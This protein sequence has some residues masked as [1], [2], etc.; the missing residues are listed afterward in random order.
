MPE[1]LEILRHSLAHVLAYA[2]KKFDPEVQFGIGPAI[3]DGFYYDFIFSKSVSDETLAVLEKEMQAIIKEDLPFVREE[4]SREAA[5][6][7]FANEPHKLELIRELP[8]G[9]VISIYTLGDFVD[10]CRGPHV[11]STKNLR[12]AGFTLSSL[13]GAYWRGNSDNDVM[14]RI[15]AFAF[16][17]KKELKVFLKRRE[18]ALKRDHRRLGE[19]LDLFV[20]SDLVGKGLPLMTPKG[21]T[22]RRILERF[23]VD[24]EVKRGYLHVY[25]PDL[26]RKELY[27]TSG[28]WQH[29]QDSMYP[30]M[31]LEGQ[32]YVLRP[33]SCP[34]HFM[35]YKSRQ[36]SYRELPMRYAEL[37]SQFRRE[38][39]G[40]LS[41]LIRVMSFH[42]ADSHILCRADQLAEE[43]SKT[44]ELA[45]FVMESLGIAELV[46]Y[47]ASLHDPEK[48]KFDDGSGKW[49]KSESMLLA[50]L[51]NLGLEYTVAKG[52]AAFYGPKLDIQIKNVLGKED[53][54]ITIQLD[55]VLPERFD[56]DYVTSEDSR[57]RPVVIHRSSIGCLE[58]TMAF[59]IEHYAG[60]FPSWFSPVNLRILTLS[61]EIIPYAEKFATELRIAGVRVETDFRNESL[62]KKIREGRNA[63]IPYLAILG[64]NEMESGEVAIRNRDTQEQNTLPL[65]TFVA[66][67]QREIDERAIKLTA[68]E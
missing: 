33:M 8:E 9:E 14:Q 12:N 58:R 49:E 57:E 62:G 38:L 54:I 46:T 45:Q 4:L 48:D 10:L 52:E 34:H 40:T 11:E 16:N 68:N 53:T 44:V 27:E 63:R 39:S 29:Y 30:P 1:K 20:F 15:Y 61:E 55:F 28:H 56:L 37:A 51:D 23:I 17:N 66:N 7:K 13:A 25:T 18:E 35:L 3:E 47:R 50:A 32:E 43:F 22:I 60:K 64:A 2:A 36:R 65:A 19:E 21:S 5:L 31:D 6:E 42:L 24:E 67:L 26:G 41:G 59:L